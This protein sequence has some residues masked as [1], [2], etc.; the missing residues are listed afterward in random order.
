MNQESLWIESSRVSNSSSDDG[1]GDDDEN[2]KGEDGDDKE[3]SRTPAVIPSNLAQ[4]IGVSI[5]HISTQ[6][7]SPRTLP[8]APPSSTNPPTQ[9]TAISIEHFT[10]FFDTLIARI[11]SMFSDLLQNISWSYQELR[12]DLRELTLRVEVVEQSQRA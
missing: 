7:A 12:Q 6:P 11:S 3:E 4:A 8:P 10:Q 2:D 1:D 9:P 5:E